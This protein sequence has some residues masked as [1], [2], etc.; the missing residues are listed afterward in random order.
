MAIADQGR[1]SLDPEREPIIRPVFVWLEVASRVDVAGDGT[2]AVEI[3]RA[4]KGRW[5]GD[6]AYVALTTDERERV[7]AELQDWLG[8]HDEEGPPPW[9]PIPL[10]SEED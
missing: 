6:H 5:L 3:R 8:E 10:A 2:L 9:D 7:N 4:M 1:M